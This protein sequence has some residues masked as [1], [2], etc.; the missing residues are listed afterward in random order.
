MRSVNKCPHFLCQ[1]CVG[2]KNRIKP[3]CNWCKHRNHMMINVQLRLL[4]Q[5]YKRLCEYLHHI[6]FNQN[7]LTLAAICSITSDSSISFESASPQTLYQLIREGCDLSDT[8][9]LNDMNGDKVIKKVT[10]TDASHSRLSEIDSKFVLN[11]NETSVSSSCGDLSISGQMMIA[12]FDSKSTSND[13]NEI[14]TISSNEPP[15]ASG[16][17]VSDHSGPARTKC[18]PRRGCRCGL[19]TSNPGKLTCCGQRCTCYVDGKG[20][21]DCKCRGCR[22]PNNSHSINPSSST[23]NSHPLLSTIDRD[24][25]GELSVTIRTVSE[26]DPAMSQVTSNANFSLTSPLPFDTLTGPMLLADHHHFLQSH[27]HLDDHLIMPSEV[28]VISSIEKPL[29]D[30]HLDQ[31]T[32]SLIN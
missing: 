2:G 10:A 9:T 31:L 30:S 5:N 1:T 23:P 20:C 13:T 18:K 6:L 7:S 12:E 3:S 26:T 11:G 28:E 25:N 21:V 14:A 8:F 24:L 17:L 29:T 4:V 15:L 22:N 19:A 27:S 32:I 16:L